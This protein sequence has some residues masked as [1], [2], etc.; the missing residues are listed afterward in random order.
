MK[1][2]RYDEQ[3]VAEWLRRHRLPGLA[4][5]GLF[6]FFAVAGAS[7]RDEPKQM[8][9]AAPALPLMVNQAVGVPAR[10]LSP[11]SA[12]EP[13]IRDAAVV[14]HDAL[15]SV[16]QPSYAQTCSGGADGGVDA[17]G[18]QCSDSSTIGAY[19]NTSEVALPRPSAKMGGAIKQTIAAPVVTRA[20]ATMSTKP[21]KTS[22]SAQGAGR[23]A[24]T[25]P[26]IAPVRTSKIETVDASCSGGADG[27][28]DAT[29][30][31]C[32]EHPVA[33]TTTS[34]PPSASSTGQL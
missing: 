31:Q 16:S 10:V 25:A 11:P 4:W 13:A 23:I 2:A 5:A 26:P 34:P 1:T 18:N 32:A 27:G 24:Q 3:E 14:A 28:M 12:R 6:A 22:V 8:A 33:A 15:D 30:N 7:L 21:A 20:E 9:D 17:T 29:G 19:T